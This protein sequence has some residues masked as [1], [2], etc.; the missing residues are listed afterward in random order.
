MGGGPSKETVRIRLGSED[1][2]A[3]RDDFLD[4]ALEVTSPRGVRGPERILLDALDQKVEGRVLVVGTREGLG[5]LAVGKLFPE[6]EVHLLS[7][8]AYEHR[9][10]FQALG[11]NP[12]A[13]VRPR[14]AGDL[15]G[16]GSF[17]WVILPVSHCGEGMLSG[18]L[19]RDAHGTL[20][21]RGKILAATDG[22]RDRWLHDRID[23]IFGAVTIHLRAKHGLA[24]VA[25]K[26][27]GREPRRRDFRKRFQAA[28]LGRTL[29]L[30]TRPGVFSHGELDEGTL[31]LSEVATVGE[32][33]RV[34]DLGCGSGALG[35]AAALA[36]PR[37]HALLVD[38]SARAVRVARENIVRNGAG[39]N[40]VAILG[41]D[42]AAAREGA[43]DL[44]LANP[45]YYGDYRILEM[46]SREAFRV[47]APGGDLFLVTKTPERPQEIFRGL[48]GSSR[49]VNRRG[50][51]ILCGRKRPS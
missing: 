24:Y 3:I 45:P 10:A 37:G 17:D 44:A 41:C 1:E 25:R 43:F 11:K 31:A 49:A 34:L 47:L 33:S 42:L 5:A 2:H 8:D 51:T 20:K 13:N 15:P 21:D 29:E 23:D 38:S 32:S 36:A 50:Y 27:P 14:L 39:G 4:G 40:A 46:F 12:T 19:L 18:E 16:D 7:F 30:E 22:A 48:F 6:A 35:I 26:R 9:R 28:V